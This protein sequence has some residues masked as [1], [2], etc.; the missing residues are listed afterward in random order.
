MLFALKCA[1][2]AQTGLTI[3]VF[4]SHVERQDNLARRTGHEEQDVPDQQIETCWTKLI[5]Y[6]ISPPMTQAW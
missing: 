4:M 3:R 5:A 6:E 1:V 2:E